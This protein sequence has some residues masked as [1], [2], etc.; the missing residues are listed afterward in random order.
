[1]QH[2]GDP[3]MSLDKESRS[4]Y[5]HTQTHVHIPFRT[6]MN[7]TDTT[8]LQIN[9]DQHQRLLNNN[10]NNNSKSTIRIKIIHPRIIPGN[11][12]FVIKTLSHTPVFK[13]HLTSFKNT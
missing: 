4:I 11:Y 12:S 1:M 5:A 2:R 10:S 9:Q 13:A 3:G 7:M 8:K 6:H